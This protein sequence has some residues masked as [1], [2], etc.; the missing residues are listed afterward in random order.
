MKPPKWIGSIAVL[1]VALLMSFAGLLIVGVGSARADTAPVLLITP[2]PSQ[3]DDVLSMTFASRQRCQGD[4]E[5]G[6]LW[7]TF[8]TPIENDPA[9]LTYSLGLPKGRGFT[10]GLRDTTQSWVRNRNPGLTDGQVI[11]PDDLTFSGKAFNAIPAGEY[12][13]GVACTK[14]DA[15]G[16]THTTRFWAR[17]VAISS[18][19][20][21]SVFMSLLDQPA[22]TSSEGDS[23]AVAGSETVQSVVSTVQP[24][25]TLGATANVLD[26]E[27][28]T[29]TTA[30]VLAQTLPASSNEQV[31]EAGPLSDDVASPVASKGHNLSTP[32]GIALGVALV[33]VVVV[34]F[35]ARRRRVNRMVPS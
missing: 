31:I 7:Q 14:Q 8:L 34:V 6:Y 27:P 35:I 33:L 23:A 4:S 26:A 2:E 13:I 16:V 3:R 32:L 1:G 12:W 24:P 20:N 30:G 15:E 10:S 25:T 21:R 9:S 17:Q 29:T 28:T 22:D 11:P 19:A 18:P 5:A